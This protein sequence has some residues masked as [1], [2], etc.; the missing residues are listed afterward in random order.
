VARSDSIEF[1][2]RSDRYPEGRSPLLHTSAISRARGRVKLPT[3]AGTPHVPGNDTPKAHWMAMT[4][5]AVTRLESTLARRYKVI[6]R[7]IDPVIASMWVQFGSQVQLVR[8][9]WTL[10]TSLAMC[11]Y[12]TF[13]ITLRVRHFISVS[14]DTELSE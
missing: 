10:W 3:K 1:F 4:G 7:L 6:A 12:T 13:E 8:S 9:V 2:A 11:T 5:S 14:Y